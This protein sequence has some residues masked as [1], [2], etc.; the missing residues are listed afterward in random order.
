MEQKVGKKIRKIYTNNK[1]NKIAF[2]WCI[3]VRMEAADAASSLIKTDQAPLYSPAN[4][5][6]AI[7][8]FISKYLHIATIHTL[9]SNHYFILFIFYFFS[10][11]FHFPSL[12]IFTFF[13]FLIKLILFIYLYHIFKNISHVCLVYHL[14]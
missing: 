13:L 10:T 8:R 6:N 5:L 11:I 2:S 4:V 7:T 3:C 14:K 9:W 12:L 1:I